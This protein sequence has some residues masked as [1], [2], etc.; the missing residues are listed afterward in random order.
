METSFDNLDMYSLRIILFLLDG[1]DLRN[2]KRTGR[3]FYNIIRSITSLNARAYHNLKHCIRENDMPS[4]CHIILSGI[5]NDREI[6]DSLVHQ[7]NHEFIRNA[8]KLGFCSYEMSIYAAY[9]GDAE[10]LQNIY[11]AASKHAIR[12]T[13]KTDVTYTRD[14]DPLAYCCFKKCGASSYGSNS[15]YAG[16]IDTLIGICSGDDKARI[17]MLGNSAIHPSMSPVVIAALLKSKWNI[18]NFLSKMGLLDVELLDFAIDAIIEAEDINGLHFFIEHGYA[19]RE[20][21]LRTAA[22]T[23]NAMIFELALASWRANQNNDALVCATFCRS[24][25]FFSVEPEIYDILFKTFPELAQHGNI[26]FSCFHIS[27][28]LAI[29]LYNKGC[30]WNTQVFLRNILFRGNL[31]L[32]KFACQNDANAIEYIR[33]VP[34]NEIPDTCREFINGIL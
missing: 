34:D 12:K 30:R 13:E 21:N 26:L 23:H 8:I 1:N 19:V 4:F 7:H 17:K 5:Y 11:D 10:M 24:L 16:G 33:G 6:A 18:L 31:G 28:K 3:H 9:I 29:Y 14:Y 20:Y 25:I 2:M 22:I 15:H 32:L 27:L